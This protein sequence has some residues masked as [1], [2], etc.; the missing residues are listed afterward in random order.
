MANKNSGSALRPFVTTLVL[1]LTCSSAPDAFCQNQPDSKL[2]KFE[3]SV[4][5]PPGK[6]ADP[7]PPPEHH[8]DKDNHHDNDDSDGELGEQIIIIS[9]G[10]VAGL[11]I[12]TMERL[13]PDS[14]AHTRRDKGDILIP[15]VRYDFAYQNI[16]STI[17]ANIE[18]LEAGYGPFALF[19]ENY[20]FQE[21][22]PSNTLTIEQQ[23][24]LYRMSMSKTAEVDF[25]IGK[26]VISGAQR[27]TLNSISLPVKIALN[28]NVALEF[29]PTWA[30]T[31]NDYELALLWGKPFWSVKAGY[32]TLNS[33]G[34]SLHGPFA[35]F[36]LYY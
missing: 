14:E 11:G 8:R 28:E 2:G 30:D 31:V 17:N 15:F 29:R 18:R 23:M 9:V 7:A 24:F 34:V 27:T 20:A 4:Q 32:R 19:F 13:S 33:P 12:M 35:G 36:A 16:S 1:F 25:G 26:S 10:I 22:A 5:P 3:K 21:R 6:P